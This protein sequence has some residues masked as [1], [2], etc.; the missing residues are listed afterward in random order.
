MMK[1]IRDFKVLMHEVVF[2]QKAKI[3]PKVLADELA[4]PYFTLARELNPDDDGAKLDA[5]LILPIMLHTGDHSPLEFLAHALGYRL[6]AINA[7]PDSPTVE[8]ECLD[9][10]PALVEFHDSI[11]RG[12]S[13]EAVGTI[14]DRAIREIEETFVKHRE[15]QG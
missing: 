8:A 13:L 7:T 3:A 2:G 6:T 5:S 4:K 1:L 15:S 12:L 14:R 10:Y 11:R 9:D